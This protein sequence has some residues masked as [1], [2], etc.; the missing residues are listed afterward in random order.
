[1]VTKTIIEVQALLALLREP[2]LEEEGGDSPE[3]VALKLAQLKLTM[4]EKRKILKQLDNEIIEMLNI[5]GIAAEIEQCDDFNK[6]VHEA[7]L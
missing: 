5:E 3:F 6:K 4:K 1:M 7:L 2:G